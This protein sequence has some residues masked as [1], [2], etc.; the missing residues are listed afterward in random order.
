[1]VLRRFRVVVV[2]AALTV[3]AALLMVVWPVTVPTSS[4]AAVPRVTTALWSAWP[5]TFYFGLARQ[6]GLAMA[7]LVQSSDRAQPGFRQWLT[8]EQVASSFGAPPSSRA[9]VNNWF[10]ARGFTTAVD[11]TAS[12]VSVTGPAQLWESVFGQSLAASNTD[13]SGDLSGTGFSWATTPAVLPVEVGQYLNPNEYVWTYFTSQLL[14]SASAVR[15]DVAPPANE[16]T[17]GRIC[18]AAKNAGAKNGVYSFGQVARAYGF[19]SVQRAAHAGNGVSVGIMTA[20]SG[21]DGSSTRAA[22]KCWGWPQR[23]TRFVLASGQSAPAQM[24]YTGFHEPSL[25]SQMIRGFLP[26]AQLVNYQTWVSPN[27][28]FLA[29]S[30]LATDPGRPAVASFSYG[31]CTTIDSVPPLFD[32]LTLRLGL[33]GTAV[34]VSSADEGA[35]PC[36]GKKPSVQWP[37]SSPTVLAVGGTRLTV[38]RGNKRAAEVAWNDFQWLTAGNAGGA[39]G[40]GFTSTYGR[41]IWQG[42]PGLAAGTQRAVPDLAAH[43]SRLPGWPIVVASGRKKY[44]T[45]NSGTSAASPLV[46]AEL[47]AINAINVARGSGPIGFVAPD[48]YR[49]ARQSRWCTRVG[50]ALSPRFRE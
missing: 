36:F 13:I 38:T 42:A 29:A 48:L 7:Q 30:A 9:A 15:G 44:W 24:Y 19:D 28:W 34:S 5:V 4:S 17:W 39:S 50:A 6:D 32:A 47:A 1:M 16:G 14:P 43:A 26:K 20:G 49:L 11:S 8:S 18:R 27:Q 23:A 12:Y 25:D 37:A 22:E 2:V 41:P 31:V 46:A 45:Q 10:G 40:G 35:Y 33:M 3:V 21:V